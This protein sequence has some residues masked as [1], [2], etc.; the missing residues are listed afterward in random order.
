MTKNNQNGNL[1]EPLVSLENG[2]D[3]TFSFIRA[4]KATFSICTL[5]LFVGVYF[6]FHQ[7][8]K[9][10]PPQRP[11][12]PLPDLGVSYAGLAK[13]Q[14]PSKFAQIAGQLSL[15]TPTCQPDLPKG[16]RLSLL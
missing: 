5:L 11:P 4:S 2:A 1:D 3:G 10:S 9:S 7:C 6:A 8:S 16:L 15:L 12:A 13:L 14:V